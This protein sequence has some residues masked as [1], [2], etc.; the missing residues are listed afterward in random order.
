MRQYRYLVLSDTSYASKNAN[1]YQKLKLVENSLSG[2]IV[3]PK[4][5]EQWVHAEFRTNAERITLP[6]F[7]LTK[8]MSKIFQPLLALMVAYRYRG[9]G[10]RWIYPVSNEFT[11]GAAWLLGLCGVSPWL[12]MWDPPGVSLR[13]GKNRRAR[14]R[15]A[16][17]DFMLRKAVAVSRGLLLNLHP[18]FCDGRMTSKQLSK[19]HCF[20]NGSQVEACRTVV[21]DMVKIPGRIGINSQMEPE[22]GCWRLCEV[23]ERLCRDVPSASIVWIGSGSCY[24][25]IVDRFDSMGLLGRRVFLPGFKPHDEALK[26]MAA[27]SLGLNFYEDM[28][29][30]RWNY[31]L[32]LPEFMA[33]GIP[34]VSPDLPGSR[35]YLLKTGAGELFPAGDV[36][37][38]IKAVV[39]I[40]NDDGL[41]RD[42]AKCACE[43]AAK[44]S[45][46]RINENIAKVI[47]QEDACENA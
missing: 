36:D 24:G 47:H 19:V 20:V 10:V 16:I 46:D 42:M 44:Y 1:G 25:R 30:L 41:L 15:C 28:P 31:V 2:R 43:A 13:D 40:I 34:I 38:A 8:L 4:G 12:V 11:L 32:K 26:L 27:S 33:L 37:G 3:I 14:V 45:W 7:L 5:R 17:M 18:G 6:A 35:E 9:S 29:S 21:G 22:K 39:K 23:I